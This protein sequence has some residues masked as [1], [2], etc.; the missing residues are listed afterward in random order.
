MKC[1]WYPL[2][3]I[4]S[5]KA[6]L[7][8]N[9]YRYC[10][11]NVLLM[12]CWPKTVQI[13]PAVLRIRV[14]LSQIRIWLL[15]HSGSGSR[16]RGVKKHRIPDPTYFCRKAINKFCLLILDPD[17]TI[18]PSRIPD[19]GGKKAPDPGSGSATLN[20]SMLF[21]QTVGI[22]CCWQNCHNNTSMLLTQTVKKY[23]V[24]TN[25]QA[26]ALLTQLSNTVICCGTN[27]QD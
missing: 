13:I 25:C 24:D 12:C 23:A 22:I 1:C 6:K 21:T 11:Q 9:R 3:Q 4:I 5:F 20:T 14:V 27:C 17:P 2:M 26:N 8:N 19:P 10:W 15:L 7:A 18:A 16:I